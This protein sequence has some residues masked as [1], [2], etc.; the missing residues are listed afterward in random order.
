VFRA[1]AVLA[2]TGARAS[3]ELLAHKAHSARDRRQRA[4]V[5][6]GGE[7]AVASRQVVSLLRTQRARTSAAHVARRRLAA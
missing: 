1:H 6:G 7:A 5:R 2:A 4:A 3:A